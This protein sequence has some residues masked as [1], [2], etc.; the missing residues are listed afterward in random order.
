[1]SDY[2]ERVNELNSRVNDISDRL[3]PNEMVLLTAAVSS[4]SPVHSSVLT[5]L[6]A[7]VTDNGTD[8]LADDYR[9]KLGSFHEKVTGVL[10]DGLEGISEASDVARDFFDKV[11]REEDAF[12]TIL[13]AAD[14]AGARDA[15]VTAQKN[16]DAMITQLD[17][18]WS[19]FTADELRVEQAEQEAAVKLR[20]IV[21]NALAQGQP[22]SLQLAKG[23][24]DLSSSFTVVK[25]KINEWLG[26]IARG[27]GVPGEWIDAVVKAQTFAKDVLAKAK[28]AGLDTTALAA[29]LAAF[30]SDAGSLVVSQFLKPLVDAQVSQTVGYLTPLKQAFNDYVNGTWAT[31][32]GEYK[33]Q[34][35]NEGN[36][37]VSFTGTRHD[38]D[39]LIKKNGI[40]SVRPVYEKAINALSSWSS[41]SGL[42]DGQQRDAGAAAER[43]RSALTDRWGR[44][45]GNF[46]AFFR[47]Y[48]GRILGS[49]SSQTEKEILQIDKW[50]VT[51]TGFVA[52]GLDQ[53]L[54][55][56]RDVVSTV[57][58]VPQQSY[59]SI[60][61]IF[62]GLPIDIQENVKRAVNDYLTG[63]LSTLNTER[64]AAAKALEQSSVF[65]NAE[66]ISSDLERKALSEALR[67]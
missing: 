15:L 18:K 52:V 10:H 2:D 13:G 56:W 40:D 49:V 66:K 64:D 37:I 65:T 50:Q 45:T 38:A 61:D 29:A 8:T 3:Q 35:A 54:K 31:K 24:S 6:V 27:V 12:F 28:E 22:A 9:D 53:K 5:A 1:M 19:S 16:L 7:V 11:D 55:E 44:L 17:Q 23:V 60:Q 62:L 58:A 63:V 59:D 32:I 57:S 36:I 67:K 46:E 43:M 25:A 30:T 33:S 51:T 41:G 21:D 20:Q 48:D 26:A 4:F 34:L 39:E 14:P 42:T 47:K